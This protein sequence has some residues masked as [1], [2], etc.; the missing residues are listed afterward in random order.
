MQA[1]AWISAHRAP[2][3]TFNLL[4]EQPAQLKWL[5]RYNNTI[6]HM[7]WAGCCSWY[8]SNDCWMKSWMSSPVRL[9]RVKFW[10]M[11]LMRIRWRRF[12]FNIELANAK[13]LDFI[14]DKSN[15]FLMYI[16]SCDSGRSSCENCIARVKSASNYQLISIKAVKSWIAVVI[17]RRN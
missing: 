13:Q 6:S 7:I 1:L 3:Q 2:S 5:G 11:V 9:N 15:K 17:S 12:R 8:K 16:T 14:A 10:S 4:S